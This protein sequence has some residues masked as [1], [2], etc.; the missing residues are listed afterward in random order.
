MKEIIDKPD[1]IKIKKLGTCR[2]PCSAGSLLLP[3]PLPATPTAC[4]LC[5]L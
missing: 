2:P 5:S 1:F 3:L 4:A